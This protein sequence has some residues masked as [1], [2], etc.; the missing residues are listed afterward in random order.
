MKTDFW[1]LFLFLL[2]LQTC[3]GLEVMVP[4][5]PKTGMAGS[6]VLLPCTFSFEFKE[7]KPHLLFVRWMFAGKVLLMFSNKEVTSYGRATLNTQAAMNGDA[8]LLLS[9]LKVEDEGTYS[10]SVDYN[11]EI[12]GKEVVLRVE[13]SPSVKVTRSSSKAGDKIHLECLVEGFYPKE[14][15]VTWHRN[16]ESIKHN[17]IMGEP[18][19]DGNGTYDV[20]STLI[21][22][23][24]NITKDD[25]AECR[26]EHASL[27]RPIEEFFVMTQIGR[28]RNSFTLVAVSAAI[29]FIVM[30]LCR[31]VYWALCRR[32]KSKSTTS[33]EESVIPA[34]EPEAEPSKCP[35]MGKI[36]VPPLINGT[37]ARL[38]CTISGYSPGN[39]NVSWLWMKPG[40]SQLLPVSPSENKTATV[41]VTRHQDKSYTC[42]ACLTIDVSVIGKHSA[43][44]IC[45]VEHPTLGK[46]LQ[47]KTG[48]LHVKGIPVINV[49]QA[50]K[51]KTTY[52]SAVIEGIYP[53]A[54]TI[55]WSRTKDEK[56]V[57]YRETDIKNKSSANRDGTFT[58][59]SRCKDKQSRDK[60]SKYFKVT[61]IHT[62]LESPIE[63]TI[64]REEGVYHL[65]TES[66]KMVLPA[67]PLM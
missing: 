59:N 39:L 23:P 5:N 48:K 6:S 16:G 30:A 65:L 34:G 31:G 53:N 42:T 26:V 47:K 12:V 56:Y 66:G 54:V 52:L 45:Q 18:V 17:V 63:R 67:A 40:S 20:N 7:A 44:Y 46:P 35:K 4:S 58:I 2:Q 41:E 33:D 62:S 9:D 57:N 14:I 49:M 29:V 1:I 10:C 51:N 36:I 50:T 37:T 32:L 3:S 25:V 55:T 61:V 60:K 38:Q 11:G 22:N 43:C 28:R 15:K 19:R 24:D 27:G 8:S 13:A 64:L 21:V